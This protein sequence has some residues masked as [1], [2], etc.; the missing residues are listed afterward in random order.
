MGARMGAGA[1]SVALLVIAYARFR[2]AAA[3]RLAV[4]LSARRVLG[5]A[6]THVEPLDAPAEEVRPPAGWVTGELDV[7]PAG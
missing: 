2:L 3:G 5:S 7:A 4:W 6:E 1:G